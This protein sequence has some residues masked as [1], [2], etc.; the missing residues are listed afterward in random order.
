MTLMMTVKEHFLMEDVK[1]LVMYWNGKQYAATQ[2]YA[3]LLA[4]GR[5]TCP[6]YSTITSWLRSLGRG[7]DICQ[8]ASHGGYLPDDRVDGLIANALEE[9]L[10]HTVRSLASVI[11]IPPTI[12][13]R[14]LHSRGYVVRHLQIVSHTLSMAQKAARVESA[15][16][17]KK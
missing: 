1:A 17:L 12:V 6:I 8:H 10:F 11:K 7:A 14:H 16:A 5:D 3:K 4:R 15:L 2:M 13:W 9:S